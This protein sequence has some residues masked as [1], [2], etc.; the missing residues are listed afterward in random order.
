MFKYKADCAKDIVL[1]QMNQLII[2]D[3]Q[4]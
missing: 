4:I 2:R 1:I 3:I